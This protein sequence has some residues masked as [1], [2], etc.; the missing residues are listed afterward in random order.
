MFFNILYKVFTVQSLTVINGL[1]F[2]FL[3]ARLLEPELFGHLRYLLI[4]LPFF[5]L[6]TLPTFDNLILRES[7][8]RSLLDLNQILIVR[9]MLGLFFSLCMGITLLFLNDFFSPE[10]L[11]GIYVILLFLPLYEISTGYKNYLIG[12]GLKQRVLKIQIRNKIISIIIMLTSILFFFKNNLS[13]NVFLIIFLIATTLPN[14]ITHLGLALRKKFRKNK[15]NK[16]LIPEALLTTIASGIWILSYSIDRLIV[17]RQLGSESLAYYSI[18]VLIPLMASQLIDGLIPFWYKKI[19]FEKKIK[20]FFKYAGLIILLISLFIFIYGVFVNN[21][22]HLIFG[23]FYKYSL[24][25]AL[26][27]GVLIASGS[28]EFLLIH[29]LYVEKRS[30]LMVIYN[31]ISITFLLVV[32]NFMISDLNFYKVLFVLCIKQIVL[33]IIF[34]FVLKFNFN[35][36]R[37]H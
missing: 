37:N 13:I 7:V 31:L 6:A 27:S 18:L 22:Y 33:T 30:I 9:G 10:V 19:F 12:I 36:I 25:I 15:K 34:Y 35:S 28:L 4:I 32:F 29:N 11:K 14:L 24:N 5:M 2:T 20:S 3:A 21:F 26:L 16:S 17:E 23:S 1:L 8:S